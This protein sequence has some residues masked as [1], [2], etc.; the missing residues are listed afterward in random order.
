MAFKLRDYQQ[1]A[2]ESLFDYF[3]S[4]DE[5]NPLVV[6]PTGSGKSLMIAGFVSEVFRISPNERILILQH[7]KEL[8][9]QNFEKL[10]KMCSPDLSFSVYSAGL[11]QKSLSGRCVVAGIQS[12]YRNAHKVPKFDLV[13]IDECHLTPS[14][15]SGM[16]RTLLEELKQRNPKVRAVGFTATPYRMDSGS[17]LDGEGVFDDLAYNTDIQRL[18]SEG[19][20][21][22]LV[23]KSGASSPDLS[24]V[25]I[26]GGEFVMKEVEGSFT[27]KVSEAVLY[28]FNKYGS[29]RK[30]V[31]IFCSGV[32]HAEYFTNL[33]R[34][35]GEKAECVTGESEALFRENY[36]R[37]FKQGRIRF[38]VNVDV[39]TT[40]FDAPNVDCIISLR[41]T[42]SPGLWV[43]MCGRGMRTCSGKKD[44]LV[45]DF[46]GNVER[47]GPIDFIDIR[48]KVRAVGRSNEYREKSE[49]VTQEVKI[50]QKC[51]NAC[52]VGASSC[53][54]CGYEFPLEVKHEATASS[55]Q[56]LGGSSVDQ[57][58]EVYEMQFEIYEKPGKP[59]I[60]RIKYRCGFGFWLSDYLCF[61]HRGFA[62]KIARQK[63]KRLSVNPEEEPPT[64]AREALFFAST[65]EVKEVQSLKVN[66]KKGDQF[67][68]IKGYKFRGASEP[69][70]I[71][72]DEGLDART[73]KISNV[74]DPF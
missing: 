51:R 6:A 1:E 23:S 67:W 33:L 49:V 24:K 11:G 20:L 45:L 44:C 59:P 31:L 42:Q 18:I 38:L 68:N 55:A 70:I 56:I 63:W 15:G 57:I 58:F 16:Y 74:S 3:R 46:G 4:H 32:K 61:E 27:Q 22:P 72:E 19:W 36:I 14:G 17:L 73:E 37:E 71:T 53:H 21:A 66:K 25:A 54:L 34:G 52:L 12:I 69:S 47:H 48:K 9:Q 2:V 64:S 62:A 60:F 7:R 29:D 30:S 35:A 41:P 39:L 40:G 13:V 26:R 10:V 28:E 50:C 5:G 65:G 43:Q 8:I